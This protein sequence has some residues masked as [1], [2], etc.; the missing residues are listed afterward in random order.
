MNFGQPEPRSYKVVLVKKACI[1]ICQQQS[2]D[3]EILTLCNVAIVED[4]WSKCCSP[5]RYWITQTTEAIAANA[6]NVIVLQPTVTGQD[7][8]QPPNSLYSGRVC[9]AAF[10]TFSRLMLRSDRTTWRIPCVTGRRHDYMTYTMEDVTT[11]WRIPRKTSRLHDVY[12][13]RRHDYTL[14]TTCWSRLFACGQLI[15]WTCISAS[16]AVFWQVSRYAGTVLQ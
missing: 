7:L 5:R 8:N 13:G 4:D 9:T 12:L 10:K 3:S 14:F 15:N 2:F 1:R 16:D 6:L 11:T